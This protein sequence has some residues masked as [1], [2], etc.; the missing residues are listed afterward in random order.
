MTRHT[1][2]AANDN[3]ATISIGA[4]GRTD[5]A[6]VI[7]MAEKLGLTPAQVELGLALMRSG[8]ADLIAKVIK[9]EMA[10]VVALTTARSGAALS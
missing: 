5:A 4:T 1:T 6:A 10:V 3:F 2:K 8:R 9:G 7:A